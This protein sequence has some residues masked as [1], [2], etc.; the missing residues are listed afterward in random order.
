MNEKVDIRFYYHSD[1]NDL[2][3]FFP[4]V[5]ETRN[6]YLCYSHIGQHATCTYGYVLDCREATKD[7]YK[8]LVNELESLGY[9]LNIL[10]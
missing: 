8:S 7:E 2:F 10:N 3:A 9:N 1:N 4:N 5:K 6:S